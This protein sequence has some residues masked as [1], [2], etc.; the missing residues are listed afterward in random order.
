MLAAW[1]ALFGAVFTVAACLALGSI[2]ISVLEIKLKSGERMPLAFLLGASGFHLA[3][4]LLLSL[5]VAYKPVLFA[6]LAGLI[7]IR[8]WRGNGS[9]EAPL[10]AV[11][12]T[13]RIV[14]GL[15]FATY[16]I[17][18]FVPAWAP[19][20]S[21]DGAGY[22]LEFVRRYVH[23]HGFERITTNMYASLSQGVEMLFVPAFAFGRH[24]AAALVHLAFSIALALAIFAFGRRIGKPWAGGAAALLVYASPIVGKD[25]SSAYNDVAV[26]AIAFSVFYWT[27]IWD[28]TRDSR[29]LIPIGMMAGYA[30]AAK[31]TAFVMLLY[32]MGV[33]AWRTRKLRQVLA[34]A[35]CAAAMMAPW[36]IK[37][38][39]YVQN[40]IAPFASQI[41][42]NPN[43]HAITVEHWAQDLQ[44]YE[45][46]NKWTLPL[47]VTV[48]GDKTQG[49]LGAAFL[50]A[51]LALLALRDPV[52]RRLLI[53]AFLFLATYL[54]NVGTRFLIPGLPFISLAMVI[55]LESVPV[56]LVMLVVFHAVTSWPWVL[57]YYANRYAWRIDKFPY[58]AALR[59][60]PEDRYL[61]DSSDQYAIIR[62]IDANVPVG[63][64]VLSMN[65]MP[66]AYTSREL[67][68]PYEG[69]FGELLSDMLIAARI[70][71]YQPTR[72]LAFRF[73]RQ[74]IRRIRLLQTAQAEGWRQWN[75]HEL[76]FQSG[77]VELPRRPEW[78]LRAF[79]NPWDVQLAFDNSEVTR[80]RSWETAAPG[81]Y[82]DVDFGRIEMVDEVRMETS[83]DYQW[84]IRLQI[85]AMESHGRW[86]KI[87]DHY[88]Q[89][90][91]HPRGSL[92]RAATYEL[93][94][95]GVDYVLIRDT[96]WGADDFRDDPEAWALKL[97][98]KEGNA[99]LYKVVP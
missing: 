48:R 19:E 67:L 78:R 64:R 72:V 27:E 22:H 53:P 29:L 31:Y 17:V 38:W 75:V 15:I 10:P 4:F 62:M 89:Q 55:A 85:E 60:I 79:P 66:S 82:M 28:E 69:A 37:D 39:I 16:T 6:L 88:E 63:Q 9:I 11:S 13:L 91:M 33:V 46:T 7:A 59:M 83:T 43:F 24:S 57:P 25:G 3:I 47:E 21:P 76:R 93:H 77:G 90:A 20:I 80:W 50:A 56:V 26:A 86:R 32:A 44:R 81:M 95:R 58:E 1:A 49:I 45:V 36:I 40:P 70:E 30:Y 34:L 12:W 23:A 8:I 99:A 18:Y 2:I 74:G 73:P 14:Y 68:V 61:R 54:G 71:D 41:F 35:A 65:S 97:V 98:A 5:K 51:P 92:R 52:G 84:P 96:D 87:T 94:Q 42:R